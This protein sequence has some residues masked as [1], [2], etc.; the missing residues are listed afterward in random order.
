M[1]VQI[2]F[3]DNVFATKATWMKTTHGWKFELPKPARH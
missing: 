2:I 1:G 3:G